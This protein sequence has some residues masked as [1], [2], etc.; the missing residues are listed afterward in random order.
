MLKGLGC[1]KHARN[2][3][4]V[5]TLCKGR[6]H[7]R[8]FYAFVAIE[9]QNY[10][11]FKKR[12]RPGEAQNFSVYGF[13]LMR[14]WGDAPPQEIIDHIESKHG[15][16]FNVSEHFL[17]RLANNANAMAAPLSRDWYTHQSSAVLR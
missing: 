16:E 13:E 11:Y 7:E 3:L 14:G 4:C 6:D 5:V 10:G 9:P 2:G 15:I 1:F 8:D 17:D 12:Y